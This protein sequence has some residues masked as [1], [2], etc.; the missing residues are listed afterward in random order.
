MFTFVRS[1]ARW[2]A[3][4][5]ALT[6]LSSFGQTF[7]ISLSAGELRELFSLS[8]G[9]FAQLYMAATLA[10]AATLPFLGRIVDVLSV[11]ATVLLCIPALALACL[12]MSVLSH[13]ALLVAALY[14]LRLFGQGMMTHIAITAMG[15][16]FAARRGRAV[17]LVALGHQA[18]EMILPI[19][20]AALL[21]WGVGYRDVWLGAA[22]FLL[23]AGLPLAARLLAVERVP[24]TRPSDRSE[25]VEGWTRAEVLRDRMFWTIATGVV[26]PAFIGTSLFFHQVYLVELRGWSPVAFAGGFA[27]MGAVTVG[28]A[29]LAGQLVDRVG[30]RALLPWF[31]IPLAGSCLVLGNFA[32]EWAIVPFFALL[33]FS[34]GLSQTLFGALW[35][36]LYGTAH[37][38][39]IRS[40]TVSMMVLA[41]ALGPAV[42]GTLIDFGV[43]LPTQAYAMAAYCL[44]VSLVL[45]ATVRTAR[46]AAREGVG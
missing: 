12:L 35:P 25:P 15:R 26:A 22:A 28:A 11:R 3:G 10:S 33:G 14:A 5:F 27:V 30:A 1:N 9:E 29:L 16:W 24:S 8:H 2:I 13:V 23:L 4:G 17:S 40:V 31:L 38:G 39:A 42:T 44:V 20:F 46:V 36:E 18:G 19:A 37:L 32:A 21:A 7:F 6:F 41:T 45:G 34:Y 43:A